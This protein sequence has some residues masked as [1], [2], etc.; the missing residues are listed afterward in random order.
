VVPRA[1]LARAAAEEAGGA[2]GRGGR[3]IVP[4]TRETAQALGDSLAG[5]VAYYFPEGN[6]E[7]RQSYAQ[8]WRHFG[9]TGPPP[10][11]GFVV[12][13]ATGETELVVLTFRPQRMQNARLQPMT[14][15]QRDGI[16]RLDVTPGSREH[17]DWGMPG[18]NFYR[19]PSGYEH[20]VADWQSQGGVGPPPEF[21]FLVRDV[22]GGVVRAVGYYREVLGQE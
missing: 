9:G 17:P 22:E 20:Y 6:Y 14:M 2:S 16:Y 19:G 5:G 3:L 18:S 13:S 21:G 4:L 12:R 11:H 8:A 7:A 10:E 15:Q 1:E